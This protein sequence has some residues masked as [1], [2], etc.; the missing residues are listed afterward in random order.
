[1]RQK[2]HRPI[3][4]WW[5]GAAAVPVL[6]LTGFFVYGQAVASAGKKALREAADRRCDCEVSWKRVHVSLFP[7]VTVVADELVVRKRGASSTPPLVT[8]RKLSA[9][10]GIFGMLR[11]PKHL[12]RMVFDG[13]TVQIP[14]GE[15]K[16]KRNE[17]GH[18]DPLVIDHIIADGTVLRIFHKDPLKAPLTFVIYKLAL[19]PAASDR[20]IHYRATL[21]NATPPGLIHSEGTVGPL[22][23][24]NAGAAPVNAEYKFDDADLS[25][26]GGIRGILSSRGKFHGTLERMIVDGSTDVPG[27]TLRISG[28][29]VHLRTDFHAI[30]D[31]ITGDVLLQPVRA[32]FLHSTVVARGGVIHKPGPKGK[33][34]DL[35]A[36]VEDGRVEDMLWLS[37]REKQ[38]TLRGAAGF[39]AKIEI[40]PGEGDIVDRLHI[41]AN[42]GVAG[43]HLK[44][45]LQEGAAKLSDAARGEPVKWDPA[46]DRLASDFNG[47][48]VVDRGAAHFRRLSFRTAGVDITVTGTY[49]LKSERIDLNGKARLE[50]KLS[51]TQKGVKSF[52]FKPLNALFKSHQKH[53]QTDLPIHI[54]G[55]L[56]DP[57]YGPALGPIFIST[58]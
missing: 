58:K 51:D 54:G 57:E 20:P 9:E 12:R 26:F 55:T 8:V 24:E 38:P 7:P 50:S 48:F 23:F 22:D 46:P 49:A 16:G 42:V 35:D 39:R 53:K 45:K 37:L 27:F 25:V 5:I 28:H 56:D 10:A 11:H 18:G 40:P 44:P 13:L 30:V 36:E 43:A 29:P 6:L 4:K 1:M 19:D 2:R 33:T 14:P 41:V 34:V 21:R 47:S 31:G 17:E 32:Y 52:L 15:V 3:A